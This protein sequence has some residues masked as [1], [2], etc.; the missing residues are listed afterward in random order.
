MSLGVLLWQTLCK[1][2]KL[3][4]MGNGEATRSLWRSKWLPSGKTFVFLNQ[5]KQADGERGACSWMEHLACRDQR[6]DPRL[7]N[8]QKFKGGRSSSLCVQTMAHTASSL[9]KGLAG[10]CWWNKDLFH[11]FNGPNRMDVPSPLTSVVLWQR[12]EDILRC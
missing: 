10:F 3:E 9:S 7:C 12:E 11:F 6:N 5:E 8:Q 2:C 1:C 4:E